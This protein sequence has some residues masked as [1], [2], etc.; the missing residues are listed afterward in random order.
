M[1]QSVSTSLEKKCHSPHLRGIFCSGRQVISRSIKYGQFSRFSMGY[2]TDNM[3]HWE[4]THINFI[5][6][7]CLQITKPGYA[8]FVRGAKG[9]VHRVIS[10]DIH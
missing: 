9:H 2:F 1:T 7:F 8:V 4:Q 10:S 5:Y 3:F 6:T